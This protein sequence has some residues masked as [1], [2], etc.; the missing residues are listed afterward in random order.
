MKLLRLFNKYEKLIFS[1]FVIVPFL[2]VLRIVVTGQIAFWFDPARDLFLA[3]SNINKPSLIGQPTGVPGLF[4]GPFW[5]WTIS[6]PMLVSRDPRIIDFFILTLPYFTIFPL[7]IY[8]FKKIFGFVPV[9]TVWLL[10]IF[11]FM[12]YSFQIWNP[13][14]APIVIILLIYLLIILESKTAVR[15]FIKYLLA[16]ILVGLLFSYQPSLFLGF[17]LGTL[18]FI[19]FNTFIGIKPNL[20]IFKKY[21]SHS[22]LYCL[23]VLLTFVPFII[24]EIKHGFNQVNV[25]LNVFSS[26]HAVVG[27]TGLSKK[28]ILVDFGNVLYRIFHL[29]S[30][31]VIVFFA[32]SFLL[33][34]FKMRKKNFISYEQKMLFV[35][36]SAFVL[37]VSFV[38]FWTKNPV[39]DYHFIGIEIIYLLLLGLFMNK[40]K[41]LKIMISFAVVIIFSSG[42]IGYIQSS[43]G[44]PYGV[45]NLTTK[46]YIVDA[47]FKDANGAQFKYFAYNPAIYTYDFDY[48]F[49]QKRY[50]ENSSDKLIYLIIPEGTKYIRQDFVDFKTSPNA[51]KTTAKWLIPDGTIILKREK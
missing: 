28:E 4:Y 14:L 26:K 19:V 42:V 50:S 40:F 2:M 11:G 30:P 22:A 45:S 27:L 1:F 35:L 13:H 43:N 51:Y 34:I 32:T 38:Y 29:Q 47:I 36:L 24:F 16:G 44:D 31:L 3:L 25:L 10:F 39:W 7:V 5:I 12:N 48:I 41:I 46:E 6:V 20:N 8:K 37:S 17:N 21:I 23:G 49:Q 18:V 9:L 15:N 33:F